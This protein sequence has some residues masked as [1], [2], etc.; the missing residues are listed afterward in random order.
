MMK[1]RREYVAVISLCLVASVR[2]ASA[3][4]MAPAAGPTYSKAAPADPARNWSGFYVGGN[5]GY[6]WGRQGTSLNILDFSDGTDFNCWYCGDGAESPFGAAG[7]PSLRLD[8]FVAGGQ[9]GIKRQFGNWVVGIEA[10]L[11]SSH[12]ASERRPLV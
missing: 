7:S 6:M 12:G 1:M 2:A 10:D 5:A 4:D 8:S 9:A 11:T 3:A